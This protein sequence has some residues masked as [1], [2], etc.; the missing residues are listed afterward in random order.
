MAHEDW[1]LFVEC[2]QRGEE[3]RF[4]Y[5]PA[6][7]GFVSG[8]VVERVVLPSGYY[9][10]I[11]PYSSHQ[12]ASTLYVNGQPQT[13]YSGNTSGETAFEIVFPAW[14]G[15]GNISDKGNRNETWCVRYTDGTTE[16]AVYNLP[17]YIYIRQMPPSTVLGNS[18][19]YVGNDAADAIYI[20]SDLVYSASTETPTP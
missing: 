3:G 14:D 10:E 15:S 9:W 20:G 19:V 16:T 2:P 8:T 5:I 6:S 17:Y 11:Y 4:I 12:S 18:T 13:T 1:N 7:G